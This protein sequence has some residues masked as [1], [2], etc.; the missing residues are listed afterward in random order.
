M[1]DSQRLYDDIV[2]KLI[3]DYVYN[4]EMYGKLIDIQLK[5]C[6]IDKE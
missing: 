2:D 6:S 5:K 1:E 4:E 3:Y